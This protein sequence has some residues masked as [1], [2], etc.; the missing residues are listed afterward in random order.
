[1]AGYDNISNGGATMRHYY[2]LFSGGFDSTLAILKVISG[3][4]PIE[5]I[6][7]FFDYG[8][9][10]RLEEAAAAKKTCPHFPRKEQAP[11]N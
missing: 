2:A 7:V 10:S 5:L 4:N 6:P 1:M 3:R 11:E 9:K 8:Q